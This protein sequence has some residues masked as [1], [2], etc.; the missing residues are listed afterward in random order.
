MG[1]CEVIT[2][3]DVGSVHRMVRARVEINKK[4]ERPKKIQ[5]QKPISIRKISHSLQNRI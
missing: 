3:A 1:N 4:L 5:K 2:K